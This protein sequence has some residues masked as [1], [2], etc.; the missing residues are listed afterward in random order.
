MKNIVNAVLASFGA[1]NLVRNPGY[2]PRWKGVM[3]KS[4]ALQ[5]HRGACNERKPHQGEKE[6]A[7]R[8]AEI[9][10]RANDI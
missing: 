7:R 6:C 4:V 2:S 3:R 1:D 5:D 9:R 10:K 8:R